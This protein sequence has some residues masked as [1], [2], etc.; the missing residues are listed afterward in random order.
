MQ[1]YTIKP[2]KLPSSPPSPLPSFH[3]L[4]PD[5][6]VNMHINLNQSRSLSLAAGSR[7]GVRDCH[8]MRN[9]RGEAGCPP[10]P[11]RCIAAPNWPATARPFP[12]PTPLGLCSALST[13]WRALRVHHGVLSCESVMALSA[14]SRLPGTRL[15]GGEGG[16]GGADQP[17]LRANRQFDNFDS[18]PVSIIS[19]RS[20]RSVHFDHCDSLGATR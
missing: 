15:L 16:R 20:E 1:T 17:A 13:S 3:S 11:K 10:G 9:E 18:P 6:T 19:I 7:Q 5:F 14:V 2:P 8:S 12:P 4:P